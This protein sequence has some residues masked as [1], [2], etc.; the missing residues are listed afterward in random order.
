LTLE[1]FPIISLSLLYPESQL[2]NIP[3]W[4]KNILRG[5]RSNVRLRREQKYV[6]YDKINNNSE[7]FRGVR[8]LLERLRP[9]ASL[10][11]GY[12]CIRLYLTDV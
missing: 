1:E 8:L 6:K 12:V 3:R 2:E 7:S 10:S 9:L 11:W 4:G 5:R